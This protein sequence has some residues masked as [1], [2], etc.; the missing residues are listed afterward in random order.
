[1]TTNVSTTLGLL[2]N[3]R[4]GGGCWGAPLSFFTKKKTNTK[5]Q[6]NSYSFK[7]KLKSIFCKVLSTFGVSVRTLSKICGW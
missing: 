5:K 6:H 2:R 1:M 4:N 3:K 7:E